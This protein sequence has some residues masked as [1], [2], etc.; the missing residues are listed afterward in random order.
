MENENLVCTNCEAV[1]KESDEYC[2][3]CGVVYAENIK[4]H[5]HKETE[6]EGICLICSQR[7]CKKCGLIIS[8]VFLCNEHSEYEIIEGMARIYGSNNSME[9]NYYAEIL[10][11][12]ALHPIVY[13]RHSISQSFGTLISTAFGAESNEYSLN[14]FKLMLPL[15]EVINAEKIL[16]PLINNSEE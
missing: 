3:N 9:I 1:I 4:C 10:E 14:E 11:N 16:E 12:E 13:S 7:Y 6:A 8:D 2:S 5:L 15:N